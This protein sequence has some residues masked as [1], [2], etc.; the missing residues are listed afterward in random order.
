MATEMISARH[1]QSASLIEELE[2]AALDIAALSP[3]EIEAL[4]TKA[5]HHLRQGDTLAEKMR[6]HLSKLLLELDG[7]RPSEPA[8]APT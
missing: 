1:A 7:D 4:L 5:A 6:L 2:R 8:Q 3:A